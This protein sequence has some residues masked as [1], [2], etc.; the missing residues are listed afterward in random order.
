V[1]DLRD[2]LKRIQEL[3]KSEV[4]NETPRAKKQEQ[5]DVSILQNKGWQSCGYKTLKRDVYALRPL[6]Q[7]PLFPRP[8]RL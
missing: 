4:K 2:R 7:K 5:G 6:N 3:K 8:W 1:A